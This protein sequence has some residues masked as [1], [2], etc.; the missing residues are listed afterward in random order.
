[1]YDFRKVMKVE[2]ALSFLKCGNYKLNIKLMKIIIIK[3][4]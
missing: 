4:I 2:I 3:P 1:V